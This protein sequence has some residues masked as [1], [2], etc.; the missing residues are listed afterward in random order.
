MLIRARKKYEANG[1]L[2]SW[3]LNKPQRMR[4]DF[5]DTVGPLI[6]FALTFCGALDVDLDEIDDH[7]QRLYDA[8]M[9]ISETENLDTLFP[10]FDMGWAKT[11]SI[12][13]LMA[14]SLAWLSSFLKGNSGCRKTAENN[15]GIFWH[16][17]HVFECIHA[18][19]QPRDPNKTTRN[20]MRK[21]I[22]CFS[23]EELEQINEAM[24]EYENEHPD[25]LSDGTVLTR[26][27][28]N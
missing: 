15:L 5:E 1:L 23:V 22:E 8:A 27:S 25:L 16:S 14:Y 19:V 24:E 7:A 18:R 3:V 6:N 4:S 13:G 17:C 26:F 9:I 11:I 28:T 20:A 2:R 21:A 10:D 12:G